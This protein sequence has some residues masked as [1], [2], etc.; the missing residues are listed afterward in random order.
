MARSTTSTH[1]SRLTGAGWLTVEAH[2]RH[3]YYRL[4]R[5]E[6]GELIESVA[7]VAPTEPV[8]S[9]SADIRRRQLRRARTCYGHLAGTTRRRR[10]RHAHRPRLGGRPRRLVPTRHRPPIDE[11]RERLSNDLRKAPRHLNGSASTCPAA[12]W[13]AA[14]VDWTQRHH[15]AG[16][17]IE[18]HLLQPLLRSGRL[19]RAPSGRAIMITEAWRDRSRRHARHRRQPAR[20]VLIRTG[21]RAL[22]ASE[23]GA[24]MRGSGASCSVHRDRRAAEVEEVRRWPWAPTTSSCG[25]PPAACATATCRSPRLRRR[26]RRR[27]C[28]ATRAPA[29]SRRSASR[30]PRRGGRPGDRRFVPVV[31]HVLVLPAR[32]VEPLRVPFEPSAPSPGA[33][34]PTAARRRRMTGL[35]TFADVMT[36]D[37]AS[38]VQGARP[39]SPTSSS[40]SS[41]A[42]SPP[43]SARRST[44]RGSCPGSSVAVIGCGGVGQAV[45]RALASPARRG[46]SPS[47]RSSSS[48]DERAAG[49]HRPG[50]PDR[51][52]PG[53]AG[54]GRSP[55]AGAPTTRSR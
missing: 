27:W 46:S 32:P 33:S 1:L 15:L 21:E 49:R 29:S 28:S 38:V 6:I 41:A 30:H 5:D 42:A 37:E 20:R 48:A 12:A 26:C 25:S 23:A 2:G 34:A 53:R 43:V 35:G 40:R 10:D 51:R 8:R 45:S 54:A 31:R 16:G 18:R 7:R 11:R 50:R 36:V 14:C 9:L 52:R 19:E 22:T 47:T 39:T 24:S 13:Y 17:A 4:Q 3:R 55:V 44:P